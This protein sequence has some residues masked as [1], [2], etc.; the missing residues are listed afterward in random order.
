MSTFGVTTKITKSI[1]TKTTKRTIKRKVRKN[2]KTKDRKKY[3]REYYLNNKD[4]YKI[5]NNKRKGIRFRSH[6]SRKKIFV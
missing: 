6:N 2:K 4:K 3:F 1:E 5:R